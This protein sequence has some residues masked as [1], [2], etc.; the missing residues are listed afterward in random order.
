MLQLFCYGALQPRATHLHLVLAN[1][2]T[3]VTWKLSSWKKRELF[4]ETMLKCGEEVYKTFN[5]PNHR[6]E[7]QMLASMTNIG[8]HVGRKPRQTFRKLIE[9][10]NTPYPLQVFLAGNTS[11]KISCVSDEDVAKISHHIE[12]TRQ[13][14]FFHSPYTINLCA[15]PGT[16]DDYFTKSLTYHLQLGK[17]LGFR[18]VVV[19]TGKLS[20]EGYSLENMEKN[21]WSVLS[22][23]SSICPLLIETPA[24]EGTEQLN[25]P[26]ELNDF[27]KKFHIDNP[28]APA[29]EM[30]KLVGICIDTCHV[31]AAGHMPMDYFSKVDPGLVRLVHFND[32]LL[33][34]NSHM[35]R[36]ALPGTGE[37]PWDQLVKVAHHCSA[38]GVPMVIE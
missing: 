13:V 19:H 23:A 10:L 18:G 35:D 9:S 27:V 30:K 1:Q 38:N 22:E 20:R 21:I 4:R 34:F 17:A 31:F 33:P 16:L 29:T 24:R 3:I 6:F 5:R 25:D 28:I 32:S 12:Q 15:I 8:H 7:F 26:S 14:M 2:G 11:T 37:I 36:H